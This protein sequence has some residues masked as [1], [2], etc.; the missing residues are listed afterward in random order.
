MVSPQQKHFLITTLLILIGIIIGSTVLM[1]L[2]T[3][4]VS[5]A[6]KSRV[7][8]TSQKELDK[9]SDALSQLAAAVSPS[10]VNISTTKKAD[11]QQFPL[12]DLY[13]HPFFRRFFGEPSLPDVPERENDI[14]AL[15][16]G[17]IVSSNGYILTNNHV[18]DAAEK[19]VLTLQDKRTFD[20]KLIGADPKTDLAL[21]KIDAV[22][23]P[24]LVMNENYDLR[25][26]ELVVAV[27]IPF[28]LSHTVT[29]GIV[30]AV[31]RSHVG[32]VDYEDFIQTD[33][34]INPG[35]SGG[36]L[37][38]SN[39]ELVG[40]NTAIFSTSGGS[41][42]VGFAIPVKMAKAVM[43]SLIKHGKVIRGWL[44]VSIQDIT[45]ELADYFELKKV[46]GVLISDVL[47]DSPAQKA[48]LRQED[49]VIAIN[50]IP[51]MDSTDLK[52]QI[53]A[54]AP[55]STVNITVI[56]E[57]VKKQLKVVLGEI[58]TNIDTPKDTSNPLFFYGAALQDLTPELRSGL[59]LPETMEGVL[60]INV[61]DG[62]PAADSLQ[63]GDVIIQINRE[64][65]RDIE[66]LEKIAGT[67]DNDEDVLL[68]IYRNGRN[69]F[70]TLKP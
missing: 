44:G 53:A 43:Q 22:D 48:G 27:G 37:V 67:I 51:V 16:S 15:G 70:V 10:V 60:V 34:A 52:N 49:I 30:S 6:E 68:L 54:V 21:I 17:V 47:P 1:G 12:E 61:E 31:G 8:L 65:I 62:T 4:Q 55:G 32:I 40:I 36:A 29:M 50:D 3:H 7:P 41:M 11:N 9:I 58:P 39:G 64:D 24:A 46:T 19:I 42:G 59:S 38:N 23:L 13:N 57:K 69:L 45:Q 35:N 63:P 56:R 25:V 28:G 26:G 20:A 18:I 33:A 66:G 2:D 5:L 14:S